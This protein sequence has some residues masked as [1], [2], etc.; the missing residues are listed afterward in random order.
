[1]LTIAKQLVS[2]TKQRVAVDSN[3]KFKG[4]KFIKSIYVLKGVI[5]QFGFVEFATQEFGDVIADQERKVK[6]LILH[7]K[8]ITLRT[9]ITAFDALQK[10]S[11][12]VT[13]NLMF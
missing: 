7:N 11:Q 1:V 2:Q 10:M 5:T 8:L 3:N 9:D 12:E 13:L 4:T 6:D